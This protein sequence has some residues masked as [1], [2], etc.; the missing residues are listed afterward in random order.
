EAQTTTIN[1]LE[2]QLAEAKALVPENH[3]L[4]GRVADLLEHLNRLT[5]ELEDSLDANVTAGDRIRDLEGQL[6]EHAEKIRDLRRARV[7]A[8]E[9][10]RPIV[11]EDEIDRA[12]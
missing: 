5:V 7:S 9:I 11:N 10:H 4:Q 8:P 2:T 3:A 12:A 6:H 1:Q